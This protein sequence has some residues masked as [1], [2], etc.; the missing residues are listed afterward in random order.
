MSW[1]MKEAN[2]DQ[3]MNM[4]TENFNTYKNT[5]I[6][7]YVVNGSPRLRSIPSDRFLVWSND[8]VNDMEPTHFIKFLG[9][10]Q[11]GDKQVDVMQRREK[12]S[13]I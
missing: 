1:Y 13:L 2:W 9:K 4:A 11:K 8:P 3:M 12:S 5:W 7:P 6:E 10:R